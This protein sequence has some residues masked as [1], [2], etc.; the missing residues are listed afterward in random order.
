MSPPPLPSLLITHWTVSASVVVPAIAAGS[1]YGLGVGHTAGRWPVRR[2]A[3]FLAGISAVLIALQSGID[4]YDDQMLSVHM[5][6]HMLLVVVVPVLL[7]GG[8]PLILALRALPPRDRRVLAR[9]VFGIRPYV[10]PRTT[11]A[12]FS[13]V[14][15]L[16]HLPG[17]YDA[18]LRHSLLHDTEHALYLVAGLLV[19]WHLLDG[20]PVPSHRLGSQRKLGYMLAAMA[21]M[22]LVGVYLSAHGTLVYPAYGPPAGSLGISALADQRHAGVI[23]WLVGNLIMAAICLRAPLTGFVARERRRP[24]REPAVTAVSRAAD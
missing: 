11:L 5:V 3:S 19:W 14:I 9:V 7:L 4:G 10:G 17:F 21:P 24:A 8:Q 23:M 22:A 12:F 20:D 16:T 6:Q 1:L 18:T 15:V 2:S 13:A